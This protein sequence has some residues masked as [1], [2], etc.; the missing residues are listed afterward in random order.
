MGHA[1]PP[2]PPDLADDG[3][4]APGEDQRSAL[5]EEVAELSAEVAFL[6]ERFSR[7]GRLVSIWFLLRQAAHRPSTLPALPLQLIR[8]L[9]SRSLPPRL[10]VAGPAPADPDLG[11]LATERRG[12]VGRRIRDRTAAGSGTRPLRSLRVAIVADDELAHN[13][14]PECD[15]VRLGSADWLTQLDGSP[16]E[17]LLVE[18]TWRGLAG[19]WQYRVAWEGHPDALALADL[20]ALV[21]WC[22]TRD[23]PT[24][25]WHTEASHHAVRF[26][27]A[28][29]LFDY[30]AAASPAGAA[31]FDGAAHRT[32]PAVGLALPAVQPRRHHPSGGRHQADVDPR[33]A[34][35]GSWDPT[36]PLLER[37]QL[38]TLLDASA[39]YDLQIYDRRLG[40]APGGFD[41]PERFRPSIVGRVA[42]A[43]IPAVLRQHALVVDVP[44]EGGAGVPRRALEALACGS[45]VLLASS[46]SAAGLLADLVLEAE[47]LD[48]LKAALGAAQHDDRRASRIRHEAPARLYQ[49]DTY[50]HRLADIARAV[51]YRVSLPEPSLTL[52]L[53]DEEEIDDAT[54]VTSV[55]LGVTD[56]R[57]GRLRQTELASRF[58]DIPIR[59][60][61]SSS[62]ESREERLRRLAAV[63]EAG[64]V[65]IV[66]APRTGR[67]RLNPLYGAMSYAD[68]DIIGWA[69][70]DTVSPTWA[71]AKREVVLE[72]GWPSS[73]RDAAERF[74][75][76]AADGVV[77][78][79]MAPDV[80][81]VD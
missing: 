21:Q 79:E 4:G 50:G 51:G 68:A 45:P 22:R 26:R 54:T 29:V 59:L 30:V 34:H 62:T 71:I 6:R 3:S 35:I 67:A 65:A 64:W 7:L 42:D 63:A 12:E 11:A 57:A 19:S 47:T 20:T 15:L 13:L 48:D 77:F 44:P 36:F 40:A 18:S 27:D 46:G 23:V 10:E 56:W 53:L 38:E 74:G 32:S 60:A 69:D 78:H 61:E 41:F 75:S 1:H 2:P 14:D 16:P 28:A 37:E 9:R 43:Q 5:E 33:P 31:V 81:D 58:G 17:M 80:V 73:S 76:W 52:L 25:F 72:R 66:G 8:V 39:G 55:V 70:G 24:V 49:R